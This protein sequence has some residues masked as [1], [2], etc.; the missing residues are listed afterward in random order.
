MYWEPRLLLWNKKY[1]NMEWGK[2]KKKELKLWVSEP[3]RE[4]SSRSAG[5]EW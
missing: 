4:K 3:W 2:T 5:Q 1:T